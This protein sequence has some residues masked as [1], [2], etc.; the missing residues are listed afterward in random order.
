LGGSQGLEFVNVTGESSTQ[1]RSSLTNAAGAFDWDTDNKNIN[2][3]AMEMG[4]ASHHKIDVGEALFGDEAFTFGTNRRQ[5]WYR[6][7]NGFFNDPDFSAKVA[8]VIAVKRKEHLPV[9]SYTKL[10]FIN[11]R[12]KY[13]LEQI[14]LIVDFDR[15]IY[16]N[17][18]IH[19]D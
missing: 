5:A 15:V 12:F 19:D 14:S 18:L 6:G 16:F 8:G 13:M 2:L 3:I 4:N 1:I 9:S 17:E 11:D 7:N 10:L